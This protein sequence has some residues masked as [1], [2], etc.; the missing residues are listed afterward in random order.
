MRR[1]FFVT[2]YLCTFASGGF[3]QTNNAVATNVV[4]KLKLF[5]SAHIVEK[6]YLNVSKPFGYA[7][8]DTIYFKAYVTYGEQNE[9]SGQSGVLYVDLIGPQNNIIRSLRLKL[10]GG[11]GS[12]DFALPDSI[13]KGYY[14]VRAFTRLMKEASLT[15]FFEQ[16]IPVGIT[17]ENRMGT[18]IP[19]SNSEPVIQ[20]FPEG[21]KLVTGVNSKVA[22]QATGADGT[23]TS[24]KGVIT[25]NDG[26]RVAEF[27][28]LHLGLGYFNFQPEAGKTYKAEVT[29]A[30]G[31][32]K[33]ADLPQPNQS[34]AVLSIN[35]EDADLL[36]INVSCNKVYFDENQN[37]ELFM[38]INSGTSVSSGRIKLAAPTFTTALKKS[39]FHTGIVQFTL[40]SPDGL[41]LAERMAFIG[42]P[43]LLKL[44]VTTDKP[45]FAPGEKVSVNI[46][47]KNKAD[48][49]V[50]GNFSVSVIKEP[51]TESNENSILSWL[52]LNSDIA[53][54]TERPGYYFA[55]GN[56]ESGTNLDVLLLT[57]HYRRFAW[58]K[59][60][61]G[62]YPVLSLKPESGL[63][64]AGLVTNATGK[65][66]IKEAINLVPVDGGQILSQQTDSTGRFTFANLEFADGARFIL[67]AGNSKGKNAAR[68]SYNGY[69]PEPV[70][71]AGFMGADTS[72]KKKSGYSKT[73]PGDSL[74]NAVENTKDGGVGSKSYKIP[75]ITGSA[76]ADQVIYGKDLGDGELINKLVA[77]LREVQYINGEF[78]LT[79]SLTSTILNPE[80]NK[81]LVIVDGVKNASLSGLQTT[82]VE[83]VEVLKN[84]NASAYGAAGGG[85]VLIV[86]TK[87]GKDA[88]TGTSAIGI[89]AITPPGFYQPHDFYQAG[90]S[91]NKPGLNQSQT[92]FWKADVTTDKNGH[93]S[94]SFFN[95]NENGTYRITVEGID[96]QGN[97]ARQ[98]YRYKVE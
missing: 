7:P 69:K 38:I 14:R 26:K 62:Q 6:A 25:N 90:N 28:T 64:I 71:S 47:S 31:V 70:L 30:D 54:K 74:Q 34:G 32:Q 12:G 23:G 80:T 46:V 8:G 1:L 58:G 3:A 44:A 76:N 41:P 24:V 65:P 95:P 91:K 73:I 17:G 61:E 94:L 21:G 36:K 15:D 29:F 79:P 98:I 87:T 77:M 96:N 48:S 67:K 86:N 59:L 39:I 10:T 20:F 18:V 63:E 19:A 68:I 88:S 35:N 57:R 42:R 52:L 93:A 22:F 16:T 2:C 4:A 51:Q 53:G 60:L 43:D 83:L 78:Y 5:Y 72:S 56:N 33:T 81:M 82:D 84:T 85:G 92:V 89:L 40:F 27:S 97:L 55:Q 49:L 9:L 11:T 13:T 37:K 66:L 75:R 45:L 50:S